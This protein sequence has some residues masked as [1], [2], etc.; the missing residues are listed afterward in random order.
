MST[1]ILIE[2]GRI[3]DPS[4][5]H[6]VTGNVAIAEKHILAIGDTPPG[7][8]ADHIIDARNKIVAPGLVDLAARLREPGNEYKANLSSELAA[9]AA[10]GVTSVIVPPDSNPPLDEPGLVNMLRRR[11]VA[12]NLARVYPLGALTLGLRGEQLAEMVELTDAGCIAFSQAQQPLASNRVLADAF[13]YAASHG[14]SV[15]L[16]AEDASLAG[17]GFAHDGE[18]A[19]RL[20]LTAIP[21][22]AETIA[23]QT[24]IELAAA[25]GVRLHVERVSSAAGIELI[26]AAKARALPVTCDVAA[27]HLHLTDRDIGFFDTHCRVIPPFRDQRDRDAIQR[28]AADGTIDAICSDHTPVDED[29]KLLPFGEAEPGTTAL[30]LLLPLALKWA[31][32]QRVPLTTALNRISTKPAAIAGVK[33]GI[34]APGSNADVIVF[35]PKAHWQ[36]SAPTLKSAGKNTPFLGLEIE[37][38]VIHTILA[39]AI[40]HS[41]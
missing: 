31:Q 2:G 7:F 8:A 38:R 20:G 1:R 19:T 24:L 29:A 5:G 23:L 30:E 26:R 3:I 13:K 35:D 16:R 34:L 41:A 25:T 9:A 15:W 28:G 11:A 36:V 27:H 32:A 17:G 39:G 37:G 21:V 18:T 40:V 33:G 12:L 10:G 6:D 4:T 22:T 14:L